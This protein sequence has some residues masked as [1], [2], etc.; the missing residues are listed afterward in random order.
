MVFISPKNEDCTEVGVFLA[1]SIYN[2]HSYSYYVSLRSRSLKCK[3]NDLLITGCDISYET[4]K[5][6]HVLISKAKSEYYKGIYSREY[7]IIIMWTN[8]R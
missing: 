8:I 7:G 5:M 2:K 6:L 3:M 4:G 1:M